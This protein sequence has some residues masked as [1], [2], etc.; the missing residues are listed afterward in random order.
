MSPEACE[1]IS[2]KYRVQ[3]PNVKYIN[4]QENTRKNGKVDHVRL[5]KTLKHYP[6]V[7]LICHFVIHE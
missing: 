7:Y 4:K 3:K 5:K 2:Y 6:I 1:G